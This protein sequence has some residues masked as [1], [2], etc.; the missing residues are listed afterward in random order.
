MGWRIAGGVSHV[1][2]FTFTERRQL[3]AARP[4]P[5]RRGHWAS[6][7]VLCRPLSLL[8]VVGSM[9]STAAAAAALVTS[10]VT[11]VMTTN[12]LWC[13]PSGRG[14]ISAANPVAPGRVAI[15]RSRYCV[16]LP[17]QYG[18]GP[19]KLTGRPAAAAG[20]ATPERN[21]KRHR[22]QRWDP[23]LPIYCR[24]LQHQL[25]SA[26]VHGRGGAGLWFTRHH[27]RSYVVACLCSV[28]S[29]RLLT[30]S[31]AAVI[32]LTAFEAYKTV[33]RHLFTL[34]LH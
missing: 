22:R 18:D 9:S 27:R 30:V 33:T 16:R 15:F 5:A 24:A 4:G 34:T 12:D 6:S 20:Q 25:D 29:T 21:W 7:A 28:Q 13:K 14:D 17:Y 19:A 3:W 23:V 32:A 26:G 31:T 2:L 8:C 11:V 1:S 10:M